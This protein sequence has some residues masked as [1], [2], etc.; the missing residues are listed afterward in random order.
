MERAITYRENS[1]PRPTFKYWLSRFKFSEWDGRIL[2]HM[3]SWSF[4]KTMLGYYFLNNYEGPWPIELPRKPKK[5]LKNCI[6]K[7]SKDKRTLPMYPPNQLQRHR[8]GGGHWLPF[9]IPPP[10]LSKK[11]KK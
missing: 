10:P 11:E 7:V 4:T 5:L 1:K 8:T 6:P 9:N 2:I 3:P